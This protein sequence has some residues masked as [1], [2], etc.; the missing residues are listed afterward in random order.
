MVRFLMA[1]SQ[2]AQRSS[3][4]CSWVGA[5]EDFWLRAFRSFNGFDMVELTVKV[6]EKNGDLREIA[7]CIL[8]WAV[9]WF[10]CEAE[11]NS[12]CISE[13]PAT[14]LAA[15]IGSYDYRYLNKIGL[16]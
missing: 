8:Q 10:G 16:P 9:V 5:K 3:K 11:D 1:F 14:T 7:G 13:T 15:L 12:G 4:N 6:R 2:D